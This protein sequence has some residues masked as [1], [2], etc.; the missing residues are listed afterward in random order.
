MNEYSTWGLLYHLMNAKIKYYKTGTSP[1]SDIQYDA[2]ERTFL[3]VFGKSLYDKWL[4]VGFNEN[5]FQEIEAQWFKEKTHFKE[6]H[7]N[8]SIV[9]SNRNILLK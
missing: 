2:M 7:N 1:L 4:G 9:N 5:T 6:R 3:N 8:E